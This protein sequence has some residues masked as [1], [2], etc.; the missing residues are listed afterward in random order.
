[1]LKIDIYILMKYIKIIIFMMLSYQIEGG[2]DHN[3]DK[4]D[5]KIE[6]EISSTSY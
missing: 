6:N 3:S 5:Y 4:L 2:N 1:M